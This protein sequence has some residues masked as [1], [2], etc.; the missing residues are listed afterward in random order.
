MSKPGNKVLTLALTVHNSNWEPLPGYE[1]APE[2]IQFNVDWLKMLKDRNG[3]FQTD[4]TWARIHDAHDLDA[5]AREILPEPILAAMDLRPMDLLISP[6]H[7]LVHEV[8]ISLL[9]FHHYLV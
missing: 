7:V 8:R 6:E 9:P 1:N 3:A 5:M 4:E 2:Y